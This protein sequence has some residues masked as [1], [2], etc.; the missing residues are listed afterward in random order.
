MVLKTEIGIEVYLNYKII[1]KNK[2][3]CQKNTYKKMASH[4][5]EKP[6]L[7]IKK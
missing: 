1:F 3:K 4:Y 6:L 2:N 7:L 5:L